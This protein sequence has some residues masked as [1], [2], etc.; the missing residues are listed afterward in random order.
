MKL[1]ISTIDDFDIQG[2][3]VLL[4]LD[5]NSPVDQETRRIL[6]NDFIADNVP[7]VK[8]LLD[9]GAKLAIISHQ[10]DSQN[11]FSLISMEEHSKI[12]SDL[13]EK[14][15]D[16]V[17]DVAGPEARNS[18][19]KLLPG[20]AILLGNL[21]YLSEETRAFENNSQIIEDIG[22]T[23]LLRSLLP[24]VDLY[25]NDAFSMAHR[26][27]PSIIGFERFL[28]SAGGPR[29][30]R[31]VEVLTKILENP[32]RPAVFL[33]GGTE[34]PE[35]M[36]F[37]EKLLEKS[38]ADKILLSNIMSILFLLAQ[39]RR[40]GLEYE[41]F[42]SDNSLNTYI[43]PAKYLLGKYKD[44]FISPI[45]F[46]YELNGARIEVPLN[47]LPIDN[48]FFLDIGE[49]TI[50]LFEKEIVK[51]GSIFIK[52]APG[53]FERAYFEIG[54][55]K[56]LSATSKIKINK[57]LCGRDCYISARRFLKNKEKLFSFPTSTPVIKFITGDAL[58]LLSALH[59][60]HK[61]SK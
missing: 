40:I 44:K 10:G 22:N 58:P 20:R 24:S 36:Q 41:K 42:I 21:K 59:N 50:D 52:G 53:D 39:G 46:A 57:I 8:S 48:A 16:Y 32:E 56:I 38:C 13:I 31:S 43:D 11:F 17:D 55:E 33:I 9:K 27:F 23:Y 28:P 2:K 7:T 60:S 25:V 29:L 4:Y 37:L 12:L 49:G 51:A 3:R 14:K 19:K 15:V 34:V 30:I 45:D 1:N 26:S 47:S 5:M 18:I 54:T 35:T 6:V 61:N